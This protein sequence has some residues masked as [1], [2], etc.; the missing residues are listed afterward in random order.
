[1]QLMKPQMEH[2]IK[3][4][5]FTSIFSQQEATIHDRNSNHDS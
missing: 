1:M 4:L 3:V 2:L 5:K